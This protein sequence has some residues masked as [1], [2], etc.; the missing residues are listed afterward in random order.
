MPLGTFIS[1]LFQ[2]TCENDNKYSICKKLFFVESGNC[3]NFHI[4][5]A[6]WQLNSCL[7]T[8]EGGNYSREETICGNTEGPR[9][10]R[11]LG[12]GKT[13]LHE[14]CISGTVLSPL[15]SGKSPT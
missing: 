7:R 9:L 4:I 12:L 10:T 5:S 13:V 2:E 11:I 1:S 8:I 14:I 15:L 6:L 3:G